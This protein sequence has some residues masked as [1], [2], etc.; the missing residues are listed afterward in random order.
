MEKLLKM[1]KTLRVL[2]VEDS[3][4]YVGV[5]NRHLAKAGYMAA[6]ERVEDAAGMRAALVSKEW[7]VIF[8]DHSMLHFNALG[9]M[10]VLKESELD[11]PVIVISGTVGED[12]AVEAMRAG[13]KDYL[14]KENLVRLVPIIE[15]ELMEAG[16]RRERKIIEAKLRTSESRLRAIFE[17]EPECVK[18]LGENN[19]LLDMNPAGLA[20]IEADSLEQA[21]QE[22]ITAVV[23]PE[24]RKDFVALTKKIFTGESGKLE[25][26]IVGLK[27]T[28]RW[29]ET[30]AAPFRNENGR[31]DALIGI[32]RD[33]SS[34]RQADEALRFQAHL[35]DTVVEAVI[36]TNPDGSISYWNLFAEE[37]YGWKAEEVI[38]RNIFDLV[39]PDIQDSEAE[40]IMSESKSESGWT[41]EL[42]VYHRDGRMFPVQTSN[43]PIY[44]E[45]GEQIG[46]VG[47]SFDV[48]ERKLADEQLRK[49]EQEQRFLAKQLEIER[50]RLAEAQA[51]A[52]VGSWDRN[53]LTGIATWSEE[54]YLIFEVEKGGVGTT[55]E[56]FLEFVHPDDRE[57]VRNTFAKSLKEL[58][59]GSFDHRL[60]M[61]DGR[62]KYVRELWRVQCDEN[63]KAIRAYGTTQ[64]ITESKLAEEELRTSKENFDQLADN[65]TDVFW[66]R[67]PDMKELHY[68][69]PATF[70][71]WGI[72]VDEK[73]ADPDSFMKPIVTED[74][75]RVRAA[76]ETLKGDTRSIDLEYRIE[77]GDD[78]MRWVRVRAF[79]VRDA[80][81][82]LIRLTGIV[83]DITD[84]KRAEV[85]LRSKE[86][87]F[88]AVAETAADSIII[89]DQESNLLYF[90]QSTEKVFG[91]A[92]AELSGQKLTLLMPEYLRHVHEKAIGRYVATGKKL[93]DWEGFELPGLH[94][95]GHEIPLEISFSDFIS[96]GQHYF[97]AIIRDI[98][99]RKLAEETLKASEER[100]TNIVESIT[101]GFMTMDREWLITYVN[102]RFEEIIRPLQKTT[103]NI[104]GK[105]FW[106][107]FPDTIGTIFETSYRRAVNEQ[108]TMAFEAFYP[109][110]QSWFDVRAYPSDDGLALY[111]LDVTERKNMELNL[112][113]LADVSNDLSQLISIDEMM[114]TVGAK[115]A[116][117][118]DLSLCAIIEI[119]DEE[120]KLVIEDTWH[121]EDV[122]DVAGVYRPTDYVSEDFLQAGRSGKMTVV[123]DTW[124]DPITDAEHFDML[125]I[126]S[127]LT[128]PLIQDRK[129]R[130][131]LAVHH[132]EPHV[133][134]PDEIELIRE[135]A[136]RIWTPLQ[137]VR[138][139]TALR[140]SEERLRM[141]FDQMK[142][143]FY[144]STHDGRFVDVNPAMVEMFGYSSKEEMLE[145]DVKKDLYFS[146]DERHSHVLE[147]G[148]D[149][150]EV[151]RM[152][153]KDGSVIWV[154]D[155]GQYKYDEHGN[156]EFH[157]GILRDVTERRTVEEHLTK[158]EERY[159]DLVENAHDIIYSHDLAGNYTSINKAG[160][161]IIGYTQAEVL[162]MNRQQI[163]APEYFA[164]AQDMIADRLNGENGSAYELAIIAKDGRKIA[165]EVNTKLV[166]HD[167]VPTGV[168]GIAR[169][170]TERKRLEEQLTQA[171]KLE[172]VGLLAG[173]IA[174]DFNNMLTAIN[175]YS[176]LTLR[177]MKSDDPLRG[178]IEEIKNAG[179]RSALLTNQ[180]L[181]FS[182]QQVL[183]PV[184]LDINE[185]ITDTIKLLQRLIGENI[186]LI[187]ALNP[188]V[189]SVK[190]DAGQ[191]SQIL[192]NLSVNARDAMEKGGKLTIETANVFL[193]HNYTSENVGLLPG[194]YVMLSV[195][196]TGTGMDHQ[197]SQRMFE[198]FFTTKEIGKGTGLGLATVYG[199]VKQSGG[200]IKAYSEAGHG[201][202]VK[203]YLPRVDEN[204]NNSEMEELTRESFNGSETILLVED[205]VIVRNLSRQILE[206]SGFLVIEAGNGVEALKLYER[207]NFKI[208][209][210]MTD[211]VMP[212][213]G[214]AEL[215]EVLRHRIPDLRILFTSGYTDD[216]IV[217]HGLLDTDAN[218]IQKPFTSD[219][220][221][222]RVRELLDMT[223]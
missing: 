132:S 171:Q 121:R 88:R 186:Q 161:L 145:V 40:K 72:S 20:M 209:L 223:E 181:A 215:A 29:M 219:T 131:L 50:M 136:T 1:N 152:Q 8:C 105:I 46:I 108:V 217:R 69:S 27:G 210:L 61:P 207:E 26:E 89:I 80:E 109:P 194:A 104:L 126:R 3:Q 35:L 213:M 43:S 95:D 44:D 68:I 188:K 36:A 31:I 34:R 13:A 156:V 82:M 160:E 111:F 205:E 42:F 175:G 71:L 151:F 41:G 200:H 130:F 37:L 24:Y 65:I 52:K 77:R 206:S 204:P 4:E 116:K 139:E 85:E 201:T 170:I 107:E 54:A 222:K 182:R 153:R 7:D 87:H 187:M 158:S 133:W 22:P 56:E 76:F 197:T 100:A 73:Y 30:H 135:I 192:M 18:L 86:E 117:H 180:L 185:V 169:D 47:I 164:K 15:R 63:G 84:R 38:G 176:E 60:L 10:D 5:L 218:F 142:D 124:T 92:T 129:W 83:T 179:E 216:A 208:D 99:E 96:D 155:R 178:N 196:D 195:S 163:I 16:S 168:Q 48:S 198:P 94:K 113:F 191:L 101:D 149:T 58:S 70:K 159:R 127:F 199:I 62:I 11:I 53:L 21:K 91:Y 146:P 49:S 193:D 162:Q 17:T 167:G 212:E 6:I 154:E 166:F 97:T 66:I 64:D 51:I 103:K 211:V 59:G 221:L 106:D 138:A 81:D 144:Y 174:H 25:F 32:T 122:P 177:R 120:N 173:G 55:H 112:A 39:K 45:K 140:E 14:L 137:R 110:L 2:N 220:L 190:V 90:N 157:Q 203:V 165:V 93:L 141:L 184:V 57:M 23:A 114:R 78:E 75:E 98:T 202:S 119:N 214:G 74:R 19:E 123:N 9:V 172:S 183:M 134:R 150:S 143:G 128:I 189:G 79:Q 67:S 33:V 12:G 102:S 28:H 118:F 148:S 125:K 115:I 147:E